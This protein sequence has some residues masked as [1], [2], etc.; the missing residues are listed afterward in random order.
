MK[1][2][3]V[4]EAVAQINTYLN[5]SVFTPF[6]V[7]VDGN[8]EYREIVRALG[9]FMKM[10]HTSDFCGEDAFPDFDKLEDRIQSA[11]NNVV[12]V[13]LGEAT[14]LSGKTSILGKLK[15]RYFAKK[16]VILGRRI[17]KDM[18]VL[19]QN[20]PKF[21][22]R[23][24]CKVHSEGSY[25]VW[26]IS[27]KLDTAVNATGI[28]QIIAELE[29]GDMVRIL[30][31]SDAALQADKKIDNAYE[32]LKIEIPG[33]SLSYACLEEEEW[34]G[35]LAD[36]KV[37]GYPVHHWRTYIRYALAA[38]VN[39][40]YI[41]Y[42]LKRV[43][44]SAEYRR[45][46]F[47]GLLDMSWK[48]KDFFE[49]YQS[50]KNALKEV[51]SADIAGYIA[52]TTI[53]DDDRIYYL[54]DNTEA[55]RYEIIK[56]IGRTEK[57]PDQISMI[58]PAIGDYLQNYDFTCKNGEQI[59]AYF[60]EYKQQKLKNVISE[61]FLNLVTEQAKT[62]KRLFNVLP[63][64][65]KLLE[66]FDENHDMLYWMDALGV[67]YLGYIQKRAKELKLHISVWV[68]KAEL[69]TLTCFNRDFYDDWNEKNKDCTDNFDK[70]KH[71]GDVLNGS[72]RRCPYPIHLAAELK[73][74]DHVLDMIKGKL[75]KK[76]VKRMILTSDHGAS[77]LA[78]INNKENKWKMATEGEHSGRCCPVNEID[79]RPDCATEERDFW[80]L[81][82]YDRFKGGRKA[83]VE[84][85]GGASLEEVLVPVIAFTQL[86]TAI[87]I[88]NLTPVTYSD[89]VDTIPQLELYSTCVL[90]HVSV[91]FNGKH[92][93]AV[94]NEKNI[95]KF[96][97]S[98]PD[99]RNS[100]E[101]KAD[102]YADDN[103]SDTISFEIERKSGSRK[104]DQDDFFK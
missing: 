73:L 27:R 89:N 94:R 31:K 81:A 47:T 18:A 40:P 17:R 35:Y 75:D 98:F 2:L 65:G 68:G 6:F 55:E 38:S 86:N 54:T 7:L 34:Q 9:Q 60:A 26:Q 84:V 97:V 36:R 48:D 82:N 56:E 37:E 28:K 100:G 83:S 59:T 91:Y 1:D 3:S 11:K 45:L 103:F 70:L 74:I 80:V 49:L 43:K 23:R 53:R 95:H 52:E 14:A 13:G 76:E 19:A 46:I 63:T 71:A 20:D 85:H 72:E 10:I 104:K 67:E 77:R 51:K 69:P 61:N 92:Y 66:Q 29:K 96:L 90:D 41:R 102:V 62:G 22:S 58:Y 44:S 78:V 93:Q 64:R 99:F 32:M 21:E 24:Y 12:V 50:R 79:E 25:E 5:S 30:V 15:D 8:K 16:V 4:K 57:I 33:F 87:D 39:Q 88:Q 42:I 101:Y